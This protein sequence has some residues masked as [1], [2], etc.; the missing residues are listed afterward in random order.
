[1]FD[2]LLQWLQD[3]DGESVYLELGTQAPDTE[4]G[5]DAP[6]L[7][8]HVMLEGIHPATNEDLPDQMAVMV[9]LGSGERNRLYL[10]PSRITEIRI[11]SDT[12]KVVVLGS[13]YVGFAGSAS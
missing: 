12:A 10:E 8:L 6:G 4:H 9:K 1:M 11:A 5:A 3:R 7:A 2:E 13:F